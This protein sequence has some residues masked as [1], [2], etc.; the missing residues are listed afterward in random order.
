MREWKGRGKRGARHVTFL[1]KG[2]PK[3]KDKGFCHLWDES[4]EISRK[5]RGE[6][7]WRKKTLQGINWEKHYLEGTEAPM[8]K[9]GRRNIPNRRSSQPIR[10]CKVPLAAWGLWGKTGM[11]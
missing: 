10:I 3:E 7:E 2:L 11:Q 5:N 4:V 1:A 9:K 6:R 8:V